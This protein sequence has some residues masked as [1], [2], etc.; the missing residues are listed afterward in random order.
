[1]NRWVLTNSL[2]N[3]PNITKPYRTFWSRRSSLVGYSPWMFDYNHNDFPIQSPGR[4]VLSC[5]TSPP[6]QTSLKHIVWKSLTHNPRETPKHGTLQ[7]PTQPTNHT[8]QNKTS[9]SSSSP[10]HASC[11]NSA[12]A[13]FVADSP[14]HPRAWAPGLSRRSDATG[15][16]ATTAPHERPCGAQR[17]RWSWRPIGAPKGAP[18]NS[19]TGRNTDRKGTAWRTWNSCMGNGSKANHVANDLPGRSSHSRIVDNR[20]DYRGALGLLLGRA[21]YEW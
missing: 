3:A 9:D 18:R 1:M 13:P 4:D 11:A 6:H 21:T 12:E 10:R 8:L 17:A 19:G 7:P 15:G 16:G 20:G 2:V 5:R 14:W